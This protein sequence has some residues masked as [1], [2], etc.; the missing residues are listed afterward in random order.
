MFDN[1]VCSICGFDFDES[2]NTARVLPVCG[3]SI[4][5]NC[6]SESIETNQQVTCPIDHMSS[7]SKGNLD[8]QFPI[9]AKV[10]KNRSLKDH[11]EFLLQKSEEQP[12]P[13]KNNNSV[14]LCSVHKKPLEAVCLEEGCC[15]EIC[16]ACGLFGEHTVI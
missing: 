12:T 9:K 4:C 1:S 13:K 16:L 10:I 7:R 15:Q 6:L 14:D 2:D 8:L 5:L 3:H 11:A